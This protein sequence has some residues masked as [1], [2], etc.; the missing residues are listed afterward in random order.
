VVTLVNKGLVFHMVIPLAATI[1]HQSDQ[2]CFSTKKMYNSLS[3]Y[4]FFKYFD[5]LGPECLQKQ[6][7]KH[8]RKK[9]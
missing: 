5:R 3:S 1:S 7:V 6:T 4:T 8:A 9:G 2:T